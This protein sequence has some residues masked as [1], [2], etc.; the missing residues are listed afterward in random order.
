MWL[1][2]MFERIIPTISFQTE[3][4]LT[5]AESLTLFFQIAVE[6][7]LICNK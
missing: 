5:M 1:E 4:Y 2:K 7:L 3:S 6:V